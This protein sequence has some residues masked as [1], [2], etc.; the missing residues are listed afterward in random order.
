[1]PV[2]W[3]SSQ[4][5]DLAQHGFNSPGYLL[6]RPTPVNAAQQIFAGVELKERFR[7]VIVG[8][9]ALSH[10]IRPVVNPLLKGEAVNIATVGN[11]RRSFYRM[12]RM[13]FR[14]Y[15]TSLGTLYNL[16]RSADERNG[17][18]DLL[19][20]FGEYFGERFGL[21]NGPGEPIQHRPT[22]SVVEEELFSDHCN[23]QVIGHVLA[24]VVLDLRP[25]A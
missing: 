2:I 16:F 10:C 7:S 18:A 15:A 11:S 17:R 19:P 23:H 14:A 22:F 8:G 6:D 25:Q 4:Q 5:T 13:P 20:Q 9:N 21:R 1:M 3:C 12:V 24:P